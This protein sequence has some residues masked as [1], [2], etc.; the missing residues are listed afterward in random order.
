MLMVI[1]QIPKDCSL[2]C[3]LPMLIVQK[4]TLTS[5]FAIEEPSSCCQQSSFIIF[6]LFPVVKAN[7]MLLWPKMFHK[8]R[9]MA[10]IETRVIQKRKRGKASRVGV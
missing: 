2:C 8:L 5:W 9:Q 10:A 7:C 1:K 6:A 3:D 4:E